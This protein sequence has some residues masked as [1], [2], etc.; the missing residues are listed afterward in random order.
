M[1][2]ADDRSR[3]VCH[4]AQGMGRGAPSFTAP[5]WELFT[6]LLLEKEG[7]A[8]VLEAGG[9]VE[10]R[11]EAVA[12]GFSLCRERFVAL[13]E[14]RRLHGLVEAS[15]AAQSAFKA[16]VTLPGPVSMCGPCVAAAPQAVRAAAGQAV[17]S[18]RP[19]AVRRCAV[20]PEALR[21]DA[22]CGGAAPRIC[23]RC[24]VTRYC[25]ASCQKAHWRE[26]RDVCR[27]LPGYASG[28][29]SGTRLQWEVS[30]P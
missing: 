14:G 21:C 23:G 12:L 4:R 1:S 6:E 26:H 19:T 18:G 5:S 30:P 27:A 11:L 17:A 2:G 3:A 28:V 8:L 20:D 24:R 7:A 16:R 22:G 15:R 13:A 9:L 25:G 29:S 10:G